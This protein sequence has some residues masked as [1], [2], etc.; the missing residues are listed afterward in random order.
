MEYSPGT[1]RPLKAIEGCSWVFWAPS[2]AL[3]GRQEVKAQ[4][5]VGGTVENPEANRSRRDLI[6][7]II[8]MCMVW[9]SY[10]SI[11]VTPWRRSWARS[12]LT[13]A[14]WARFFSRHRVGMGGAV[15][16]RN[17]AVM[18]VLNH[19]VHLHP[20]CTVRVHAH[21]H[22]SRLRTSNCTF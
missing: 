18:P 4:Q 8:R 5:L 10:S 3:Y 16:G 2:L 13:Y 12:G 15:T 6:L 22:V 9:A 1:R 7:A 17:A 11:P 21:V 20:R 19:D 14:T